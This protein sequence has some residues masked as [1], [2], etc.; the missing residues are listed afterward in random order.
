MTNKKNRFEYNEYALLVIFTGLSFIDY[1]IR[2]VQVINA[3]C[4]F[5]KIRCL[6]IPTRPVLP[7][8][9]TEADSLLVAQGSNYNTI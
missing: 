9:T 7:V 2:A 6:V 1:M 8:T 4:T 3:F 5:L